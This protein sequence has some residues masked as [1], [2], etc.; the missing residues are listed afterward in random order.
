MI[1]FF[2]INARTGKVL[3]PLPVRWEFPSLGW[4]KINTDEAARGY[5]SLA[6]CEGIFRGSMEEFIGVF[7]VFLEVQTAI[8]VEFYGVIHA[9]EEAQKM[10]LTDA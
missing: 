1:K 8:V 3:H 6:T 9:M 7:F 2:G 5:P 4:V 10:R